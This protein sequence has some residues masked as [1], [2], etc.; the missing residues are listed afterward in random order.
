VT[1][2]AIR[3]FVRLTSVEQKEYQAEYAI[4]LRQPHLS[5]DPPL[6][7]AHQP[8]RRAGV[9][10]AP[11][12]HGEDFAL[13]IDGA[14][15][16]HP[17]TGDPHHHPSRCRQGLGRGRHRRGRRA[18]TSPNFSTQPR[19][20]PQEMSSPRSRSSSSTSRSLRVKRRYSHT[21]CRMTTGRKRYLHGSKA[22]A[23]RSRLPPRSRITR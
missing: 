22:S 23:V 6:R 3:R 16:A 18:I 4:R 2:S 17:L 15:E 10:S 20:V 14:P 9:A 11:G 19:T 5:Y 12:R 8:Q 7:L 13:V 21:A 1:A